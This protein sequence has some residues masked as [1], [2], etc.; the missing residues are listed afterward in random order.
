MYTYGQVIVDVW[1]KPTQYYKAI[2]H[3]LKINFKNKVK[4]KSNKKISRL[5]LVSYQILIPGD[6]TIR[7]THFM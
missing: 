1:Q 5:K 7:L 3:Q 2:I 4:I 6:T